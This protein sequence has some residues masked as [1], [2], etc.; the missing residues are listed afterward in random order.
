MAHAMIVRTAVFH[1]TQRRPPPVVSVRTESRRGRTGTD[2]PS[3]RRTESTVAWRSESRPAA[4]AR[5]SR[6]AA[7]RAIE[8]PAAAIRLLAES[9]FTAEAA[10][11]TLPVPCDRRRGVRMRTVDTWAGLTAGRT[12]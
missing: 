1:D 6:A 12:R 11:H 5:A 2:I 4:R 3:E 8:S 7:C 10:P 9:P